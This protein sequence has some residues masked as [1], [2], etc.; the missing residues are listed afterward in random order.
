M[1]RVDARPAFE[2]LFSS[3]TIN[4]IY[5]LFPCPWPKEMHEKHRLFSK[6]FLCL[7]NN[8]LKSEGRLSLVTDLPA[9]AAWVKDQARNTGFTLQSREIEPQFDTKFEKK[10]RG[11]DQKQF[12]AVEF[13]KTKHLSY[14]RR[15][16]I[17]M[18]SYH[19]KNFNPDRFAFKNETG[20]T[21]VVQKDFMFDSTRE[22]GMVHV[23]VSEQ[24]LTQHFRIAIL[25]QKDGWF[26]NRADGQFFFPTPGL[27]R[28]L[29]LVYEAAH[30]SSL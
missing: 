30:S 11:R 3:R 16:L 6:D 20:P 14:K 1:L 9:Y 22:T 28:A 4:D 25:K 26:I 12:Y 27:A 13:R 18:K 29:E 10:W 7:L 24:N 8:C 15:K 17:L 19:L 23:V 2:F 21:S 5:C